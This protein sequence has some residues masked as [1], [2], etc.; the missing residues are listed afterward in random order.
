MSRMHNPSHPGKILEE[1]CDDIKT[2]EGLSRNAIAKHLKVTAAAISNI[3]NG[4]TSIT[5]VMAVKLQKAFGMSAETWLRMQ[6]QYDLWQAEKQ[7]KSDKIS[8]LVA[9]N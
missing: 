7:S 4:K 6:E 9:S 2:S 1:I 5:A 8:L 3:I